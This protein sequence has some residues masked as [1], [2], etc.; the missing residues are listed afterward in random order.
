MYSIIRYNMQYVSIMYILMHIFIICLLHFYRSLTCLERERGGEKT[1]LVLSLHSCDNLVRDIVPCI[2][3][4]TFV[5]FSTINTEGFSFDKW[6]EK[7]NKIQCLI[8][9]FIWYAVFLQ[10][11]LVFFYW[12]RRLFMSIRMNSSFLFCWFT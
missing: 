8:D 11:C 1:W 6:E 5:F 3:K 7:K 2:L 12:H 4:V 10:P 9:E